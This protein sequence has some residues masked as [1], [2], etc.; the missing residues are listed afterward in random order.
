MK[1]KKKRLSLFLPLLL[2]L[3]LLFPVGSLPVHA[4]G[5]AQDMAVHFL[6][7]FSQAER[8]FSMTEE[9]PVTAMK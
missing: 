8:T 6:F 3:T 2:A 5:G 7:S 9:T 1:H 4:E